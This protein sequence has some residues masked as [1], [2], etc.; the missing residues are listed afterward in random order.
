MAGIPVSQGAP[1]IPGSHFVN[2]SM[3]SYPYG[4]NQTNPLQT[5]PYGAPI[6]GSQNSTL[7][8]SQQPLTG[9]TTNPINFQGSTSNQIQQA[10]DWLQTLLQQ[11]AGQ[12]VG[13]VSLRDSYMNYM[14]Q[15]Q[16]YQQQFGDS[17]YNPYFAN[18]A[19]QTSLNSRQAA[20]GFQSIAQQTQGNYN[21]F[22][23][24]LYSMNSNLNNAGLPDYRT[25]S[26]NP[27]TGQPNSYGV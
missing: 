27:W 25:T 18:P 10:P 22:T 4:S 16:Q 11:Q 21:P 3:G 2:T 24:N 14:P 23:T 5:T 12:G 8:G 20:N 17:F 19:N 6:V 15:I 9:A 7:S 26:I 1:L 13:G